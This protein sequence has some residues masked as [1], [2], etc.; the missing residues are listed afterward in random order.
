MFPVR[1]EGT[2]APT[3]MWAEEWTI[4]QAALQQ[5]RNMADLPWVHG[6]R[7]MPDVHVGKG[8]TVGSVIAM[9]AAVAQAAVGVDI[10]CGMTAVRT[11]VTASDLPDSLRSMRSHIERAV[12]VGVA[13][14]ERSVNVGAL[15]VTD[16]AGVKKGWDRFWQEFGDLH[17]GVQARE[18]KA[19]K[20][21]GLS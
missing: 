3:L 11:D 4:E 14:H 7:V 2:T 18:S 6:V 15:S 13:R 9:R 20:Q 19:M 10:G 16:A 8:A 17:S 21:I 5:L 1:L 12:P